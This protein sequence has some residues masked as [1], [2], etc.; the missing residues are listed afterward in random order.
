MEGSSITP[1][2]KTRIWS[3][4]LANLCCKAILASYSISFDAVVP[5]ERVEHRQIDFTLAYPQADA[6]CDLYMEI[7]SK[8]FELPE[9]GRNTNCLK[10]LK[11]IYGQKQAGRTWAQHLR[12]GMISAP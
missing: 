1:W 3:K 5:N 9:G 7:V 12:Q 10:I 6:E 2:R 11:R 8:G 4:Q